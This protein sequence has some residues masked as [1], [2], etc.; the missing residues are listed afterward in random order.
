MEQV[1]D[2]QTSL[3]LQTL[4][5]ISI[6]LHKSREISEKLEDEYELLELKQKNIVLQ[7][8]ID[9]NNR[10]LS[11]LRKDLEDSRQNLMNQNPNPE[12]IQDV[13]RQWKQKLTTYEDNYEL[14]TVSIFYCS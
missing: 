12:N 2:Q 1:A 8:K 6:S 7:A 4:D 14:A 5:P 11:K 13:I 9:R 10:F 3:Q